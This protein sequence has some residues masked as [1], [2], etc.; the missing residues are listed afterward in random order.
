MKDELVLMNESYIHLSI[1]WLGCRVFLLGEMAS[2]EGFLTEEQR[3]MLK[4]ATQNAEMFSSA[5]KSPSPK[6]PSTLLSEHHIKAP[7]GGKASAGGGIA[8][9]HVRRS[10]SGK[11][12]RVKKGRTHFFC[13]CLCCYDI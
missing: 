13:G 11:Y 3:E 10:H 6:S 9:R 2:G 12:I 1:C 5:P 8:V 7:G 4:V